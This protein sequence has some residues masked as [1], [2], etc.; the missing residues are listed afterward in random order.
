MT[1]SIRKEKEVKILDLV[2][3]DVFQLNGKKYS[4][5]RIKRGGKSMVITQLENEK[6]YSLKIH[7]FFSTKTVIGKVKKSRKKVTKNPSTDFLIKDVK[8][9]ESV[10][11][12]TGRNNQVPQLYKLVEI[13]SAN[14]FSHVFMNPVTQRKEKFNASDN[15]KVYR[16]DELL[17]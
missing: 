1:F 5:D 15:W 16:L 4:F 10:I 17:K 2:E 12:M 9:N 3:G 6:S 13:N 8:L 11:I 7:D 14:K